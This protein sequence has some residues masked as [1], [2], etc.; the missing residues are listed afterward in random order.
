VDDVCILQ[1]QDYPPYLTQT[2]TIAYSR[3]Q[4]GHSEGIAHLVRLNQ[5]F[6]MPPIPNQTLLKIIEGA[7]NSH[8]IPDS[9]KQILP[10]P[11]GNPQ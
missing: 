3:H 5:F 10:P 6:P 2:S 1:P 7:H 11:R 8:E 4:I 9:L